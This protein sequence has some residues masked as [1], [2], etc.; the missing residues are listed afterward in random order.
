L[1]AWLAHASG[2]KLLEFARSY[3]RA[4]AGGAALLLQPLHGVHS[5]QHRSLMP[6]RAWTVTGGVPT[7]SSIT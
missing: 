3:S 7:A 4:P 5:T 1:Q 2:E 6:K